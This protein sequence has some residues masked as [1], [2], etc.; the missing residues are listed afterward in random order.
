M[1][2]SSL[3][4]VRLACAFRRLCAVPRPVSLPT[5]FFPTRCFAVE[6][7]DAKCEDPSHY[8]GP[9]PPEATDHCWS[10]GSCVNFAEW[11]CKKC[12]YIQPP[13]GEKNLFRLFGM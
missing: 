6:C 5:A 2:T 9:K 10:C 11:F 7:S 1:L 8:H 3:R 12:D 4:A 13:N